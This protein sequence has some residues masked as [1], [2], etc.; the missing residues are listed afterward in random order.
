MRDVTKQADIG[1]RL[2]KKNPNFDIIPDEV[3]QLEE[4]HRDRGAWEAFTTAFLFGYAVGI[5]CERKHGGSAAPKGGQI[6]D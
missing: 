1:D 2:M 4:I 3:K 6:N 5:R